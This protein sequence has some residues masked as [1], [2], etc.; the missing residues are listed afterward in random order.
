MTF[1]VLF[2]LYRITKFG[3]GLLRTIKPLG[4]ENTLTCYKGQGYIGCH[5][6]SVQ[7]LVR[8]WRTNKKD[9]GR[10]LIRMKNF[11]SLVFSNSSRVPVKS[12]R[13]MP[14]HLSGPETLLHFETAIGPYRISASTEATR[15][16]GGC[17][18]TGGAPLCRGAVLLGAAVGG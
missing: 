5:I 12:H 18:A 13:Y 3:V 9:S 16:G 7:P 11:G 2:L 6:P 17:G 14:A 8:R 10:I 1:N 15:S 4:E